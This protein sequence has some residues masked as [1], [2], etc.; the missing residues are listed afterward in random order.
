MAIAARNTF[1][2]RFDIEFVAMS[3]LAR[4]QDLVADDAV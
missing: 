4:L 3:M 2:L 1:V